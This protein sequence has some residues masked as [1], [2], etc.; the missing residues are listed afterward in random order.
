MRAAQHRLAGRA[1]Q[2]GLALVRLVR[3]CA[4]RLCQVGLQG[5]R[6]ASA[7]PSCCDRRLWQQ[8]G[9][10]EARADALQAE[11]TEQLGAAAEQAGAREA[12]LREP[13]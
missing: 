7:A 9:V 5:A 3:R 12:M 8:L 2:H 4:Q 13:R 6:R 1:P 10:A 11:L